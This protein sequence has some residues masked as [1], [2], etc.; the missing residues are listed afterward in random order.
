MKLDSGVIVSNSYI[1]EIFFINLKIGK[2]W[3]IYIRYYRIHCLIEAYI[4]CVKFLL[5]LTERSSNSFKNSCKMCLKVQIPSYYM[6]PKFN[7]L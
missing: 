3:T 4:S 1:W 7:K 5:T 2:L 6:V